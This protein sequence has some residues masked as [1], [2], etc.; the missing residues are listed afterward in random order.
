MEID[1]G[2]LWSRRRS[3]NVLNLFRSRM[4]CNEMGW[5]RF[6]LLEVPLFHVDF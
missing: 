6:V 3:S 5:K 2:G 1:E 4:T